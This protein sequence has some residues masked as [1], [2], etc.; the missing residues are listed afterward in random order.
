VKRSRFDLA[1]RKKRP[2]ISPATPAKLRRRLGPLDRRAIS[3]LRHFGANSGVIC[4][5][6][7]SRRDGESAHVPI[8]SESASSVSTVERAGH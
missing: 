1:P 7:L 8:S 4:S 3:L 6:L 5:C 2:A